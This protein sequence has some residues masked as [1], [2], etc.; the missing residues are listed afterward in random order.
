MSSVRAT[1]TNGQIV[2]TGP[3]DWPDGSELIVE[4]IAPAGRVGLTDDEWRDDPESIAAWVAS[5]ERIEPLVWAAGEREDYECFRSKQRQVNVDAVR[6]QMKAI[7]DGDT[8]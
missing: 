3:I 2:P 1:W 4:S 8:P 7:Q 6:R 5:V